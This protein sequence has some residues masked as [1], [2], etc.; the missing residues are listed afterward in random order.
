M[1][2]KERMAVMQAWM[3]GKQ[4]QVRSHGRWHDVGTAGEPTWL[5]HE[6][7]L[8]PKCRKVGVSLFEA[9]IAK[10]DALMRHVSEAHRIHIDFSTAVKLC[11]RMVRH[12]PQPGLLMAA[13]T[14]I[15][16]EDGRK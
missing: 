4:I 16:S 14:K 12:D 1:T 3:D 13:L 7:R 15:R 11:V 2:T 10:L 5:S 6:Y 8:K 9:D